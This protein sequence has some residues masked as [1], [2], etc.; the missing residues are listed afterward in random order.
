M[1]VDNFLKYIRYEL[2]YSTYTVLSYTFDLNQFI[3]YLTDKQADKFKPEDVTINDI[4]SWLNVLSREGKSP[5][6]IRRKVQSLRAY[7]RYL[8][9]VGKIKTNPAADIV[10]AKLNKSL[11]EFVREK[12]MA[13]VLGVISSKDDD[14][15]KVRNHL[16]LALLYST[17]MRQAELLGVCDCDIDFSKHEIKVTGKRNKQRIIPIAIEMCDEIRQYQQIRNNLYGKTSKQP[18]IVHRGKA[19]NR[20]ALY[21][22]VSRHLQS[23]SSHQKGAHVL[24]H[25]FATSMLNHGAGINSVKEILGH[26]SL[27]TTQIYT[28]ISLS[29]LKTNYEHAHP[30]ALKK[31]V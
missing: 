2:N 19:M 9:K 10:L 30:R 15:I 18:L 21:Y 20:Q 13:D 5:R 3:D 1:T 17:G 7:F 26:S 16:I 25:T 12:E 14:F 27:A 31:E 11:P 23:V 6:T 29:E 24:R 4:R 8:A 28:H 22:M